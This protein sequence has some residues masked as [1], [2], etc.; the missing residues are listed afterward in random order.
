MMKPFDDKGYELDAEFSV[1]KYEDGFRLTVESQGGS[2][3]GQ[4]P[5]NVA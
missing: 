1:E 5:R 3:K 2:T 4:P